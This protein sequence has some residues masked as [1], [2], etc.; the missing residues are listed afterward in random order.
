MKGYVQVYTGSGKGKTTAAIGLSIRAL[1]AGLK[2][3]FLQFMKS[4]AYSEQRILTG[5]VPNLHLE[6]VGKPFFIAM[7]GML[8]EEE[9]AKLQ[10]KVVVFS[11]GKP[12]QEYLDLIAEGMQEAKQAVQSGEYDLVVLD[13]INCALYFGLISWEAVHELIT[14]KA[15][16]TELVLTGRGASP[17]LIE[18]ADLVTEMKEVKHYYATQGLEARLGIEN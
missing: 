10:D 2:V 17:E 3:M 15:P 6:T 18:C 11:P 7:E 12:P 13:E 1:G 16:N 8:A 14:T 4:L 9:V 5:L